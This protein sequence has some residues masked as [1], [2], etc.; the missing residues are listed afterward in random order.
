MRLGSSEG[1][2]VTAFRAL[3]IVLW[4]VLA[5][6]T[7]IVAANHGIGLLSVFF[8]D[9]AAMGWPGQ[10]NLDF[11]FML[12]LS[13]LWVA[14]R[15]QFSG[16]GL[17]L[18]LFALFGGSFFLTAYLLVVSVKARGE[19]KEVLLGSARVAVIRHS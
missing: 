11:L 19:M 17:V 15:H 1:E 16:A 4:V 9:M 8:G 18:G 3:L 13:G 2:S 6:Y 12:V 10:F 14:W 7:T 5:G